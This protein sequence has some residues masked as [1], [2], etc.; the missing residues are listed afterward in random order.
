MLP[1][2]MQKQLIIPKELQSKLLPSDTFTVNQLLEFHLPSQQTFTIFTQ[3]DQYL[4]SDPIHYFKFNA[5]KIIT[6]P[7]SVIKS[8][9]HAV[10]TMDKTDTI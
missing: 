10:L 9:F 1:Q 7:T 2:S 5:I 6:P 8:L 4:S 3:P